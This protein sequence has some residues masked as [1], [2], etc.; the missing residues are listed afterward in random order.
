VLHWLHAITQYNNLFLI[1]LCS[2]ILNYIYHLC[3]LEVVASG[4]D[5]IIV[6]TVEKPPVP[7]T[8][9]LV[10][11]PMAPPRPEVVSSDQSVEASTF[12]E[13]GKC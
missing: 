11:T 9:S 6:Q 12:A 10:E 2:T 4:I 1:V 3:A 7:T 8:K 5:D 13:S